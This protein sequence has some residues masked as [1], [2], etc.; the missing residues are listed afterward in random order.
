VFIDC[1]T[2][3]YAYINHHLVT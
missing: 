3:M 1:E 2:I